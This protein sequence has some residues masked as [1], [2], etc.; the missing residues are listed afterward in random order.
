MDTRMT[1]AAVEV[2]AAHGA[3]PLTTTS[4]DEP[5]SPVVRLLKLKVALVAPLIVALLLTGEPP[6]RH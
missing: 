5:L 1:H 2:A 4:H 6:L 3:V